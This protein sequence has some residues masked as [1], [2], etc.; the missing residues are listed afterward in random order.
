LAQRRYTSLVDLTFA[1]RLFKRPELPADRIEIRSPRDLSMEDMKEA[2][3]ILLGAA[4]ANPWVYLFQCDHP[5]KELRIKLLGR[6]SSQRTRL[7]LMPLCARRSWARGWTSVRTPG[8]LCW[9]GML[10]GEAISERLS[11][12]LARSVP[13][14]NWQPVARARFGY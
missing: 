3:A 10:P 7:L 6:S 5:L 9:L 14:L 2:N 1:A 13:Y 11:S 4:H 8:L 12:S